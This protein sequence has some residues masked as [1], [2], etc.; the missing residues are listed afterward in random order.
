MDKIEALKA[1]IKDTQKDYY[2]AAV[3]RRCK[4]IAKALEISFE[5]LVYKVHDFH[6]DWVAKYLAKPEQ[7]SVVDT[8]S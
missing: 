2:N 5:D 3:V 1:L 4:R 8:K 7:K 6:P